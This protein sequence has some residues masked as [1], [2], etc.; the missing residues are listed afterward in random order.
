MFKKL[1]SGEQ[2]PRQGWRG[3]LIN[4]VRLDTNTDCPMVCIRAGTCEK[5]FRWLIDSGAKESVIDSESYREMF[6]G[7]TLE[8]MKG[9]IQ[10]CSADGSPLTM[11]GSFSTE[12]WFGSLPITAA[13]LHY[14]GQVPR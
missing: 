7:S 5:P 6:P 2:P 10:F 13:I 9:D 12:F 3:S 4:E 11:L 1:I 8:P 14:T